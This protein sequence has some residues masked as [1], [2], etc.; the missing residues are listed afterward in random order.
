M[1]SLV[2]RFDAVPDRDLMLCEHRGVAYQADMRAG[3]VRYDAAYFA[4]VHA[5]EGTAIS[6]AVN[7]GRID[8]MDRYLAD[9]AQILDFGAGSGDFVRSARNSGF[10]MKGFEV[11]R[12]T[13]AWLDKSGLFAQDVH[14]FDAVTMWDVIEHM[15]DPELTMRAVR[16][17]AHLFASV[18]VFEDLKRIRESKHYRP[19]EHL[20]YW[21]AQGFID[22]MALYGFRLLE[23]SAHEM[24]AGREAI[25]AFAFVRDLPDYHG[26][27]AAYQEMHATRF[28]G[29]SA[30]EL[31]LDDVAGVVRVMRPESIIDYGCGR[32]DL[33]AHFWL[34]GK[35]RIARYDP[36]IPQFQPMPDGEFD[37]ALCMDVLEHIP[38]SDVARV[39][40]EVRRKSSAALFT[41]STKPSRAKLPDGRNAHV[42]LLRPAEWMRWIGEVF[43]KVKAMPSK[44]DHELMLAAG[45]LTS[46][47]Y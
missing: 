47:I 31:H 7:A 30:T 46:H 37:L 16:R 25:A 23:R 12:E 5:Y 4:K 11:I 28:Y 14:A 32:S 33:V 3:R 1:D 43:G 40:G 35:R 38:M 45:P 20:Y 34:D 15:E 18:P 10:H 29:A 8:L 44:W 19:G 42:T 21:T 36:A 24:D 6:R 39:L 13:R 27:L 17:G 41:I 26:H 9:D 2:K 22:W